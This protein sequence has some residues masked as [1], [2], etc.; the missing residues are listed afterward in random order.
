MKRE[1]WQGEEA[2]TF[3]ADLCELPQYAETAMRNFSLIGL[4]D[5]RKQGFLSKGLS[6]AG[7]C[8]WQHQKRIATELI[9]LEQSL[10]AEMLEGPVLSRS[11]SDPSVTIRASQSLEQHVRKPG[12]FR[13]PRGHLDDLA[14]ISGTRPPVKP[15]K[16]Q[17]MICRGDMSKI[18]S[19]QLTGT[20]KAMLKPSASLGPSYA[21]QERRSPSL[22]NLP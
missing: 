17:F 9:S 6:R 10:S 11:A 4:R 21:S 8:D 14:S 5:L 1:P 20:A 18:R 3:V 22:Y 19:P 16:N 7:I 12:P 2:A 15:Q 13:L